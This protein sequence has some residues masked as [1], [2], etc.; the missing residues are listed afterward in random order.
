MDINNH[1]KK[2]LVFGIILLFIGSN[3]L[4]IISGDNKTINNDEN[5]LSKD[6]NVINAQF[7]I[8]SHPAEQN[9]IDQMKNLYGVFDKNR[10]YNVIY[11]EH[12]TGLA[13]PTEKDYETMIGS[14]LIIDKITSPAPLFDSYE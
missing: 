13:P 10:N 4:P 6:K 11:D 14:L 8:T 5:Y 3:I 12:G 1:I 7:I 2:G 9:E